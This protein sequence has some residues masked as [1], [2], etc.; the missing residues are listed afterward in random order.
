MPELAPSKIVCVGRNYAAHAKE[1]GNEVPKEPLI[2]LK[3]P[4]SLIRIGGI[5][6]P[7]DGVQ[8]GGVR[9]GD[10][11]RRRATAAQGVSPKRHAARSRDLVRGE[12]RDR[13]RSAEVRRT[14]DPRQGIRH[15][16]C[17]RRARPGTRRAR[18]TYGPHAWSTAP[19]A[20]DGSA[21]DMVF[22]IPMLLVVHLGGHDARAGRPRP[23][24]YARRAS[25]P[26]R[27][28]TW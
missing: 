20:S 9:R 2:F 14:V 19:C 6:R 24:R 25:G 7:P 28:A 18:I 17:G 8:A 11:R 10:R 13:A 15:L 27:P 22:D 23:H 1:L 12:R 16:L 4:S 5:H 3:P 26:S 21:S